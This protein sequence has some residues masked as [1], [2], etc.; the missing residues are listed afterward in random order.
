[1]TTGEMTQ[2]VVEVPE[3]TKEIAKKNLEHG[4]L[5]RVVRETL[6]RIA[7]G[8]E[9]AEAKRVKDHLETLRDER[10]TLKQ[11]R[12]RIENELQDVER[13]IERA[14]Q[15]LDRLRNIEGEYEGRLQSI[16]D[17]MHEERHHFWESHNEIVEVADTYGREPREVLN[18]IRQ[19]NPELPDGLFREG[20]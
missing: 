12:D 16:E 17:R 10:A 2:L 5:S 6:A 8:E 3:N 9:I 7:H 14:E 20:I 4:G 1:M 13:K 11:E 15:K 19:R 18:D